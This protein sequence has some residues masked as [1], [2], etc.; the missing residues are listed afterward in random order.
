MQSLC[1]LLISIFSKCLQATKWGR[2][3]WRGLKHLADTPSRHF[4]FPLPSYVHPSHQLFLPLCCQG[5]SLETTRVS[6][7]FFLQRHKEGRHTFNHPFLASTPLLGGQNNKSCHTDSCRLPVIITDNY[8]PPGTP[9]QP[10]L[11]HKHYFTANLQHLW[12]GCVSVTSSE[13]QWFSQRYSQVRPSK[14]TSTFNPY[15]PF[16]N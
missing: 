2:R 7:Y 10:H 1:F 13:W 5:T 9:V 15:P 12:N 6:P 4:F 8:P 16:L 11:S 14:S 3:G